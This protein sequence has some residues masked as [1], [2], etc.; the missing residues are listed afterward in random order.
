MGLAGP[1][2]SLPIFK[3]PISRLV[4]PFGCGRLWDIQSVAP[5]VLPLYLFT[6]STVGV[7]EGDLIPS[8]H[9]PTFPAGS[10]VM[11]LQL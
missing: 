10:A 3:D 4:R 7:E 5:I 11:D 2:E 9:E 6:M 1:S 8:L